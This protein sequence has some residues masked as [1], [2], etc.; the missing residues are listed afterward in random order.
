[1]IG[2]GTVDTNR[3]YEDVDYAFYPAGN[4]LLYVFESG[5]NR[6]AFGTYASGDRLRVSVRA[7]AV[8]YIKNGRVLYMNASAPA[9]PLRVDTS[10]YSAGSSLGGV[11]FGT[12]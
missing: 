1:L 5:A 11:T 9:Y 8:R 2:L 3:S 7:G 10:F 6:G 4:G 12:P